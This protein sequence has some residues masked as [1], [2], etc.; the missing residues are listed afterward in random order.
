[1]ERSGSKEKFVRFLHTVCGSRRGK[2]G[3]LAW[4]GGEGGELECL[5][6]SPWRKVWKLAVTGNFWPYQRVSASCE[7][8]HTNT[9]TDT[10]TTHTH[11]T[12]THRHIYPSPLSFL[13]TPVWMSDVCVCVCVCVCV[14][15]ACCLWDPTPRPR[16]MCWYAL[17]RQFGWRWGLDSCHFKLEAV[18]IFAS[19]KNKSKLLCRPG[20]F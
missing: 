13:E 6:S 17:Q 8:A 16:N 20:T 3:G 2:G 15:L 11:T 18:R 12:H 1:M 10:H 14:L 19:A 9:P 5:G 4:E 7:P